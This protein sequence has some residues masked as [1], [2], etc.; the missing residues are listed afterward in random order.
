MQLYAVHQA[1][2]YSFV[3]YIIQSY[4]AADQQGMSLVLFT[5]K[6]HL[7]LLVMRQIIITGK[8]LQ[9]ASQ[10]PGKW[11]QAVVE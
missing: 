6:S 9:H 8:K 11:Q 7:K 3:L 4:I 5:P 2:L 10:K 1:I